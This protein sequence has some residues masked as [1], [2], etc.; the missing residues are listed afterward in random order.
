MVR[1]FFK[2]AR[3]FITITLFILASGFKASKASST[4][5]A[6]FDAVSFAFVAG[7]AASI[8]LLGPATLS[9]GIPDFITDRIDSENIFFYGIIALVVSLLGAA[10]FKFLSNFSVNRSLAYVES[11]FFANAIN[12]ITKADISIFSQMDVDIDE[13]TKRELLMNSRY[14]MMTYRRVLLAVFPI[15]TL[16]VLIPLMIM[17]SIKIFIVLIIAF[18]VFL[19]IYYV[20]N[21]RSNQITLKMEEL[22]SVVNGMRRDAISKMMQSKPN[23]QKQAKLLG[24]VL[25]ENNPVVKES[26]NLIGERFTMSEA[27]QLVNSIILLF[28]IGALTYFTLNPGSSELTT[29]GF[30]I[31]LLVLRQL[32]TVMGRGMV[33]ANM[34]SRFFS[35]LLS[36]YSVSD[37]IKKLTIKA[38]TQRETSAFVGALRYKNVDNKKGQLFSMTPGNAHFVFD[39]TP[40]SRFSI[41]KLR[42]PTDVQN[43][44]SFIASISEDD[45]KTDEFS[46]SSFQFDKTNENR[47]HADLKA[48]AETI[49]ILY[50][51]SEL[52]RPS[53]SPDFTFINFIADTLMGKRSY[54]P[55]RSIKA[56]EAFIDMKTQLAACPENILF[57]DARSI[58]SMKQKHIS[59][60]VK[61]IEELG[62]LVFFVISTR[63]CDN[64]DLIE[65]T[66]IILIEG[67]RAKGFC[68]FSNLKDNISDLNNASDEDDIDF[69]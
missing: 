12:H 60:L 58:S 30:I 14:A 9:G 38:E 63:T 49:E 68:Y 39:N 35:K 1:H 11:A 22:N 6:F 8:A 4:F 15:S 40:T 19:P 41:L 62:K 32:H 48:H 28:V 69:M 25:A 17:T 57:L 37:Q 50:D 34:I 59:E 55:L 16:V 53:P 56:Y 66:P 42:P 52:R 3:D 13:Y 64:I 24:P 23:S 67:G 20:I 44:I 29:G 5:C 54:L 47:L 18:A 51:A 43:F 36:L 21:R 10:S 2:R 46:A 65:E 7:A 31:V 27:T 26:V 33:V 61:V 45:I